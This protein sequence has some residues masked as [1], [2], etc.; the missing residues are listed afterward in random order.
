VVENR[1]S[2]FDTILNLEYGSVIKKINSLCS[3]GGTLMDFG[4]GKGKFASLAKRD[5][6]NVKC[7][8]TSEDRA[9]YA[10]KTYQLEVNSN[11]YSSGNIFNLEFDVITLFHVLEHLPNPGVMLHQLLKDNLDKAGL[12]VIEVPNFNSLQSRLAK[13]RWIHLDVPRHINHFTPESLEQLLI[14]CDMTPVR[15][16]YF[17]Y[18][19]GVL[20]MVD[21]L[22]KLSGYKKNIIYELKNRKSILL[23]LGILFVL[24][25][26]LLLEAVSSFSKQGGIIRIYCTKKR[27]L[28]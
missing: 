22:L 13:N 6:W 23:K 19:L 15:K 2:I 12:A 16:A 9:Q 28:P 1:G 7:V 4:S 20:G 26:A 10:R 27:A 21:S 8:E 25:F 14:D 18:H 11:F 24:P 3:A 17:S 5:G